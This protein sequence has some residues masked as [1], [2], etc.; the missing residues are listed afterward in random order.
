MRKMKKILIIA[1]I[2]MLPTLLFAVLNQKAVP[3]HINGYFVGKVDLVVKSL[4]VENTGINLDYA[5]A[6]NRVRDAIR[7]IQ[8]PQTPGLKLGS[9][10]VWI[11]ETGNYTLTISH[12]KLSHTTSSFKR[13]WELCL[14]YILTVTD[15]TGNQTVS[16]VTVYLPSNTD[17]SINFSVDDGETDRITDGG[18]FFRLLALPQNESMKNGQYTS[19]IVFEVEADS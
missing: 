15:G 13:A 10:S 6:N 1:I 5:D 19:T 14:D 16:P 11:S 3:Q 18:I 9:F 17:H 8:T 7:P 4:G 2:L 12:D